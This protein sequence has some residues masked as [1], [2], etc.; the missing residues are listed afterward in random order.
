[1]EVQAPHVAPFDIMGE[2]PCYCPLG[3]KIP[4]PYSAFSDTTEVSPPS[5]GC[6]GRHYS[7]VMVEGETPHLVLL[8]GLWVGLPFL[9]CSLAGVGLLLSKLPC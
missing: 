7:L 9:P 4:A 6:W 8:T 3:M 5:W 1:M 2:V